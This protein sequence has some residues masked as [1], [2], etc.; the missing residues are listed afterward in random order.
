MKSLGDCGWLNAYVGI[1]YVF[2]GRDRSGLDCYG[3]VKLI[4][5]DQ[6]GETL[7]DWQTDIQNLSIRDAEFDKAINGS[8]WDEHEEPCDGDFVVC[9]SKRL[10]HHMGV[11]FGG[12]VLHCCDGAG[13]VYEPL[14]RF[15]DKYHKIQFGEWRPCR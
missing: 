7:P 11:Y 15:K 9:R 13:V 8:D 12:G 14:S 4:Y 6:Y 5:Q 2:G 10:A 3:L 1:P